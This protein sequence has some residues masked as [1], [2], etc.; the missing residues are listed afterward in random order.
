VFTVDLFCRDGQVAS[1]PNSPLHGTTYEC[2]ASAHLRLMH[3]SSSSSSDEMTTGFFLAAGRCGRGCGAAGGTGDPPAL[4]IA[5][6]P[7]PPGH[8]WTAR[9]TGTTRPLQEAAGDAAAS[10]QRPSCPPCAKVAYAD[11]ELDTSTAARQVSRRKRA[12]CQQSTCDALQQGGLRRFAAGRRCVDSVVVPAQ[13]HG[14]SV[15]RL[16]SC[17]RRRLLAD[18]LGPETAAGSAI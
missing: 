6:L 11:A 7:M 3:S 10:R 18:A 13:V 8:T 1:S 15:A 4:S 14:C 12:G 2:T 17:R 16:A 5:R 9:L